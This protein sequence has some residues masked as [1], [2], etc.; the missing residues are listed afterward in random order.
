MT[1][2]KQMTQRAADR[3]RLQAKW[4]DLCGAALLTQAPPSSLL[5]LVAREPVAVCGGL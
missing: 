5:R 4:M 3:L 1:G 2:R